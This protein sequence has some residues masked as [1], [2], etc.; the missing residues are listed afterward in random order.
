MKK[1]GFL[2]VSVIFVFGFIACNQDSKEDTWSKE[3]ET[4]WKK[5]C[6]ELLTNN[7]TAKDDA[8]DFCDCMFEKTARKYTPEEAA[9]LTEKQEQEIWQECDYQ[10]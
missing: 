9:K 10:W 3:Q 6:N 1:I 5:E 2:L 7:G 4:K 8:E